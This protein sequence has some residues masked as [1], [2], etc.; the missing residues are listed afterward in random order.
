MKLAGAGDTPFDTMA[1]SLPA[2]PSESATMVP[3]VSPEEIANNLVYAYDVH[4]TQL[5]EWRK[6]PAKLTSLR[7]A[8]VNT[9]LAGYTQVPDLTERDT[10][11]AA[12]KALCERKP[13]TEME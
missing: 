4:E 12:M 5:V 3:L 13:A 8:S 10:F 11:F 2:K 9:S 1:P 6:D 7:K